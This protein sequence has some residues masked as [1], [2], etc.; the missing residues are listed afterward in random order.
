VTHM[1][2]LSTPRRPNVL[3]S[4]Q[5]AKEYPMIS[6]FLWII[7]VFK[8]KK[9]VKLLGVTLNHHFTIGSHIDI[10]VNKCR[11]L[12]GTLAHATLY[13]PTQLLK[14]SYTAIIRTHMEYC[15][16]LF[17]SAAKSHLK[18]TGYHSTYSC[19]HHL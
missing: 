5:L 6:I 3:S 9:A 15:S 11:G 18:K 7:A 14:L 16:S 12:L 4:N 19:S 2:W 10:I 1:N 17:T 8:H 13:L